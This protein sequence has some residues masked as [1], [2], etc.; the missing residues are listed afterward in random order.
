MFK[1]PRKINAYYYLVEISIHKRYIRN[2]IYIYSG[3]EEK[4]MVIRAFNIEKLE[5]LVIEIPE[6]TS[7]IYIY[8]YIILY[9]IGVELLELFENN[10]SQIADQLRIINNKLVIMSPYSGS[11]VN[12]SY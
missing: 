4:R 11:K 7:N 1:Q 6:Q 2:N 3:E 8:I 5:T 10:Y 9:Y 12:N